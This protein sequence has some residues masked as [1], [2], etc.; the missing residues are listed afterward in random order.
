[1][2][3]KF[4][5]V[6]TIMKISERTK[7]IDGFYSHVGPDGMPADRRAANADVLLSLTCHYRTGHN[8]PIAD[9]MVL[10]DPEW[11]KKDQD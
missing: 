2:G 7:V 5:V 4:V 3:M 8:M 11:K 6:T 9:T 1:M 10:F